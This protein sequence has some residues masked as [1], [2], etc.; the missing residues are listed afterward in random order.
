VSFYMLSRPALTLV[1]T[2]LAIGLVA[3]FYGV[4]EIVVAFEVKRLPNRFDELTTEL[5][6]SRTQRPAETVAR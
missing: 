5:N 4:V 2:V 6:G 3:M 1:A